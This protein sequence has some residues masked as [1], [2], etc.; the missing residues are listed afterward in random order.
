MTVDK[1]EI[2]FHILNK[3]T[4]FI[5]GKLC[6]NLAVKTLALIEFFIVDYFAAT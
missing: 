1:H 5:V 2:L 4:V 6:N 3:R